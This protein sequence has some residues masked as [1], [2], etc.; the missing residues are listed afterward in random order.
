MD[1][2][3]TS[4]YVLYLRKSKGRAGISRQRTVTTAHIEKLGGTVVGEYVDTDR[5]AY[6]KVGGDRPAREGFDALL[7]R[8][9]AAPGLGV[10]AWHADRLLR[11]ADDTEM[12]IA[13]CATAVTRLK[14]PAVGAMT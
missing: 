4:E 5:T 7:T 12:L 10:A 3:P 9:R 6:R 8:L 2:P 13:V 14:R 1:A 11:S